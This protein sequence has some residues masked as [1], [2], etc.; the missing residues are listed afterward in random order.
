MNRTQGWPFHRCL[1]VFI[2]YLTDPRWRHRIWVDIGT[3]D[4]LVPASTKPL[5][6]LIL[7]YP[8][9]GIYLKAS[10]Q[11]AI[12]ISLK[13]IT[14]KITYLVLQLHLPGANELISQDS[15]IFDIQIH[16]LTTRLTEW[17]ISPRWNYYITVQSHVIAKTFLKPDIYCNW[18]WEIR[19]YTRSQTELLNTRGGFVGKNT[20]K[21]ISHPFMGY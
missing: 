20:N 11:K 14:L 10:L 9:W 8:Q 19:E 13:Y 3:G 6:E 2:N 5:P 16:C 15:H 7:T 21:N 17:L 18:N 12:K 1:N 4:G